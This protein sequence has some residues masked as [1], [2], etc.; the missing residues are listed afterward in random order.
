MAKYTKNLNR[1]LGQFRY[2]TMFN[3]LTLNELH[4]LLNFFGVRIKYNKTYNTD[5]IEQL[6]RNIIDDINDLLRKV[7]VYICIKRRDNGKAPSIEE[8]TK[9]YNYAIKKNRSAQSI[10]PVK[11][12][13]MP[14]KLYV[15]ESQYRRIFENETSGRYTI[16]P[17]KVKIVTKYLDKGFKKGAI[18]QIG[19]DGYPK[20]IPI[21]S[22]IGMDGEPLR[23]MTD[24]QLF[25]L[26]QDRF[27]NICL[28]KKERDKFLIQ[29]IKDWYKGKISKNGLL[30]VNII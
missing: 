2:A 30:T 12:S 1:Y 14:V 17:M 21:V 18:E 7:R 3:D 5:E 20:R 8:F 27:K 25:Y 10:N 24:K 4:A 13:M 16:D 19:E 28:D 29:I 15:T 23:N 6:H 22:M 11:E 9:W 26:L